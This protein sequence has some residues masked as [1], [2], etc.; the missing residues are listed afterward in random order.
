MFRILTSVRNNSLINLLRLIKCIEKTLQINMQFNFELPQKF[1]ANN[2]RTNLFMHECENKLV[3][4]NKTLK[5]WNRNTW[6]FKNFFLYRYLG[7]KAEK[8]IYI[9]TLH[10]HS[11]KSLYN[12]RLI[13]INLKRY[14]KKKN[15]PGHH[16]KFWMIGI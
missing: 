2:F 16:A 4:F 1:F 6:L 7:M 13:E 8:N 14:S 12:G 11:S 9:L 5:Y 3:R 10:T 15:L